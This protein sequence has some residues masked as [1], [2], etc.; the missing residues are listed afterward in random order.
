MIEIFKS[1]NGLNPPL[2]WEF[3]ERKHV[4]YNLRMQNSC[5]L[6][7]GNTISFGLDSI[8]FRGILLWNTLDD[9][10]EREKTSAGFQKRIGKW[11]GVR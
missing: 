11:F 10:V 2:I 4:T 1:M 6:P 8:S 3:H 7:S 5:K 9:S